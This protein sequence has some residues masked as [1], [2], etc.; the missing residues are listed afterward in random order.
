[1]YIRKIKWEYNWK[2]EDK[3]E[4]SINYLINDK[5]EFFKGKWD[6]FMFNLQGLGLYKYEREFL[7]TKRFE[8]KS[9]VT[10]YFLKWGI[11]FMKENYKEYYKNVDIT[12]D[13]IVWST[14]STKHKIQNFI[15]NK[16]TQPINDLLH[17]IQFKK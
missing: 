2:T 4:I 1:M 7:N 9:H 6:G 15:R 17:N 13:Q 3:T 12:E 8:I 16:I 11:T 14:I 10:F 5:I